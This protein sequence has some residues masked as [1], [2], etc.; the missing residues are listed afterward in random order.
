MKK[1]HPKLQ[2]AVDRLNKRYAD[3]ICSKHSTNTAYIGECDPN[4]KAAIVTQDVIT[5]LELRTDISPK[6]F[7]RLWVENYN[8]PNVDDDHVFVIESRFI[9]NERRPYDEKKTTKSKNIIKLVDQFACPFTLQERANEI[10]SVGRNFIE[11]QKYDLH[12]ALEG[13]W[14]KIGRKFS[15]LDII[16]TIEGKLKP[17]I[18]QATQ[19]LLDGYRT[20]FENFRWNKA[21]CETP[22]NGTP[23]AMQI[24]AFQVNDKWIINIYGNDVIPSAQVMEYASF[25]ELPDYLQQKIALLRIAPHNE[26]LEEVG[27]KVEAN[28]YFL[29]GK[30]IQF[31]KKPNDDSGKESEGQS[32]KTT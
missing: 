20:A 22:Q 12:N 14:G 1:L 23:R 5:R 6:H 4:T 11:R 28:S 15:N 10:L 21:N 32:N 30:D 19:E 26:M 31:L 8:S 2:I 18:D 27:V 17:V 24:I 13:A 16:S 9:S 3:I 25:E 29:Y 7:A